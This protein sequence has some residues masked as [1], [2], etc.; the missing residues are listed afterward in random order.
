MLLCL[1]FF[2]FPLLT[3]W[4]RHSCSTVFQLTRSLTNAE[5]PVVY[6]SVPWNTPPTLA[7]TLRPATILA[8]VI[9]KK[10]RAVPGSDI[11]GKKPVLEASMRH[12]GIARN[13]PGWLGFK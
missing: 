7:K 1:P 6:Y 8:Q 3:S 11:V 12:S 10:T 9:R 2:L 5:N 13:R 4:L